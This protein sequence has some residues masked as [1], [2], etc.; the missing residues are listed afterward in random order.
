VRLLPLSAATWTAAAGFLGAAL[1]S[2]FSS[3]TL[4]ARAGHF[5]RNALLTA[6]SA[7]LAL[8]AR[9]LGWTGS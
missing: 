3:T 5:G 6:A 9:A 2:L 7:G 8:S 4:G 1:E